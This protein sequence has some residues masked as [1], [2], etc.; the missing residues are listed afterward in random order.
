M[1]ARVHDLTPEHKETIVKLIENGFS[2]QRIAKL[3]GK[4]CNTI[5]K[6]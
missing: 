2:S 1:S 5:Q 4:S 6:F 3:T